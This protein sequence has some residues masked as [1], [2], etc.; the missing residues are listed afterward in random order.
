[1]DDHLFLNTIL[2]CLNDSFAPFVLNYHKNGKVHIIPDVITLLKNIE[3]IS[4]VE[5]KSVLL[6][7]SSSSKEG[8]KNKNQ[9]RKATKTKGLVPKKKK[10]VP[11]KGT[12]FHYGKDVH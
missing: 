11:L 1:M 6:V 4:K 3:H 7:E 12:Y 2:S 10:N 9:M 5:Q 8:F